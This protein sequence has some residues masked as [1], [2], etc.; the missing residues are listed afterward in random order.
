MLSARGW[1]TLVK[2]TLVVTVWVDMAE[3]IE[4]QIWQWSAVLSLAWE[5]ATCTVA[6]QANSRMQ[7]TAVHRTKEAQMEG[8]HVWKGEFRTRVRL[9]L[10]RLSPN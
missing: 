3:W 10:L 7:A 6:V 2:T 4:K 5:C 1:S 9:V 8:P